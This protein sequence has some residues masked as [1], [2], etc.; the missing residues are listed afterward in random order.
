MMGKEFWSPLIDWVKEHQLKNKLISPEDL[1]LFSITDDP[2]EAA[3]IV[4]GFP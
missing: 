2:A 3:K 4:R 1:D